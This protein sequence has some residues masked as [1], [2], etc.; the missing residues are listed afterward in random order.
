V[1][2]SLSLKSVILQCF[3]WPVALLLL[4]TA[5]S[6][7]ASA[8]PLPSRGSFEAGGAALWLG[9]WGMGEKKATETRNQTGSAE[10][11]TLF[12]VDGRLRSAPG[13]NTHISFNLTPVIAIES[14]FT[15]SRPSVTTSVASDFEGS[16]NLTLSDSSLQQYVVD[17]GIVFH[18]AGVR[19]NSRALPFLTVSAGYLRQVMG[20]GVWVTTGRIYGIG[21]GLKELLTPNGRIGLRVDAR[22]GI[23]DGDMML[24]EHQRRP[25]FMAGAGTFVVF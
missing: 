6:A 17:G 22:L 11:L 24:D 1:N 4:L 5:M 21:G 2:H 8:Q 25:F 18:L 15:Y 19:L 3:V 23:R 16:P 13:I 12:A 7:T 9:G 14:G 10:R 20:G